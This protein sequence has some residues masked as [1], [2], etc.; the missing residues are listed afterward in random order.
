[1]DS[2]ICLFVRWHP[3]V[4]PD[5]SGNQCLKIPCIAWTENEKRRILEGMKTYSL[6]FSTNKLTYIPLIWGTLVLPKPY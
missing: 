5:R 2:F 4:V 1:M 3:T 6:E